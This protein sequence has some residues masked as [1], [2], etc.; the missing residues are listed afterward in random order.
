VFGMAAGFVRFRL[1]VPLSASLFDYHLPPERIAQTPAARRDTSRLM[2]IDR[3]SKRLE[4]R[5]FSDLPEY[6]AAGDI[7]FRNNAAVLPARLSGRR[8]T[9]GAVECFLLRP[10]GDDFTWRCLVKPGRKLPPGG[11][12]EHPSGELRGEIVARLEDGSAVVRFT[13][14]GGEPVTAAAN[15]LGDVPLPPYISR[16]GEA[17]HAANRD[18]D[19]ERYQ[20]V[21][22]AREK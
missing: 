18:L 15:R 21:Y 22:A 10:D 2:V 14:K 11:T 12:F 7:L 20:T 6:L 4:H 3:R 16:E 1:S 19:R 5:A 8:P 13:T 9:G 17:E